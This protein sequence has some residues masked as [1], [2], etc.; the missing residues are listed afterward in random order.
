MEI[1]AYRK[2]LN[3]IFNGPKNN[4]PTPQTT[5]FAR[6]DRT[7]YYNTNNNINSNQIKLNQTKTKNKKKKKNIKWKEYVMLHEITGWKNNNN[8]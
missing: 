2:I 3:K 1:H 8:V 5:S 7:Q 6:P 4:W